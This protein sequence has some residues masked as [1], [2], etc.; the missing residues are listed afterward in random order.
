MQSVKVIWVKKKIKGRE[1]NNYYSQ[2][3]GYCFLGRDNGSVILGFS[4]VEKVPFDCEEQTP[5]D[6]I[7]TQEY[8]KSINSYPKPFDDKENDRQS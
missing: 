8:L 6:L 3:P 7:T 5:I 1:W 4:V 2:V